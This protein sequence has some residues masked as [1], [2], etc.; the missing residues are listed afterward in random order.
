MSRAGQVV[1]AAD[2]LPRPERTTVPRRPQGL[3]ARTGRLSHVVAHQLSRT[4]PA[5]P[6]GVEIHLTRAEGKWWALGLLDSATVESATGQG[7]F[8]SRRNRRLGTSLL[9]DAVMLRVRLWWRW[10]V[11]SREYRLASPHLASAEAWSQR[12]AMVGRNRPNRPGEA[13]R[14]GSAPT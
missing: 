8:V 12:F 13:H 6:I 2:A 10:P 5:A 3:L 9:R 4:H 7:S 14:E 1:V 11:L